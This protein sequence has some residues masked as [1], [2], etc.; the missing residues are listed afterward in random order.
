MSVWLW[1][2]CSSELLISGSFTS[3]QSHEIECTVVIKTGLL[4]RSRATW[5]GPIKRLSVSLEDR[6]K[7]TD[8]Q[9]LKTHAKRDLISERWHV[10]VSNVTPQQENESDTIDQ[11]T[12]MNIKE[13]GH[14]DMQQIN[15]EWNDWSDLLRRTHG[16][17]CGI[18]TVQRMPKS[19]NKKELHH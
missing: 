7:Y 1:Y 8:H 9:T 4:K 5:G 15:R 17:P 6:W 12:A 19:E 16:P 2:Y 14:R 11:M 10:E 3:T 13:H 18:V